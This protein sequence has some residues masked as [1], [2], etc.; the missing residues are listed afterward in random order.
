[1]GSPF[2]VVLSPQYIGAPLVLC[3]PEAGGHKIHTR[4]T[5]TTPP[6][7]KG[8]ALCIAFLY[9]FSFLPTALVYQ[10]LGSLTIWVHAF[11]FCQCI[12]IKIQ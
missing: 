3:M 5:H 2:D 12:I 6:R 1:M 7:K 9:I 8:L 11:L 4:H 10:G